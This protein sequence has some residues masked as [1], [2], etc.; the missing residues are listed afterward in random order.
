MLAY[1]PDIQPVSQQPHS[2]HNC[3]SYRSGMLNFLYL[4]WIHE[5]GLSLDYQR[6]GC[7]FNCSITF[8]PVTAVVP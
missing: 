6:C 8:L 5:E 1:C 7:T 3:D 2:C 4:G